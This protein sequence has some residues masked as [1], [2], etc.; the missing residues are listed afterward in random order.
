MKFLTVLRNFKNYYHKVPTGKQF[1]TK[2]SH[3]CVDQNNNSSSRM[4]VP[5]Q[6]KKK[7]KKQTSW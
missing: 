4:S 7:N 3:D 5:T 2:T 6:T 1:L